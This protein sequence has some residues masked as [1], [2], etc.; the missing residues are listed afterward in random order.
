MLKLAQIQCRHT[1]PGCSG[2]SISLSVSSTVNRCFFFLFLS[3]ISV[4][5]YKRMTS[6]NIKLQSAS[7]SHISINN[8]LQ[9][10]DGLQGIWASLMQCTQ[11]TAAIVSHT[12]TNLMPRRRPP[13]A[14]TVSVCAH[15]GLS[16]GWTELVSFGASHSAMSEWK[17]V[18]RA[19]RPVPGVDR[20]LVG[21][22]L[23]AKTA[24]QLGPEIP[25]RPGWLALGRVQYSHF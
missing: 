14:T 24:H 12:V 4:C 16:A 10:P 3:L 8:V 13:Q 19:S 23:L 22:V 9:T 1:N 15:T 25:S 2:C 5:Y 7:Y 20:I 6:H 21:Y 11:I 18:C 17:Y